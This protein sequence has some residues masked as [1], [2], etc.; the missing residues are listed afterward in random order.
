MATKS[1][2]VRAE[3]QR[4]DSHAKPTSTRADSGEPPHARKAGHAE[5]KATYAREEQS[6]TGRPSRKSSRKSAN[7]AKT[8][9]PLVHAEQMRENTPESRFAQQSGRNGAGHG[10]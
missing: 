5:K 10:H 9:A 1:E 6:T 8:D 4:S 2:R 7:H 3:A